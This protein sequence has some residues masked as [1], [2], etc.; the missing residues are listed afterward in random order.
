V[1]VFLVAPVALA[2][3][4]AAE[5]DRLR[6]ELRSLARQGRWDG[7][8]KAWGELVAT[9]VPP[10]AESCLQA[11]DAAQ[12]LGHLD[13]ELD[14][15]ACAGDTAEIRQRRESL[16]AGTATVALFG[17]KE[18]FE[19]EQMPFQPD[20]AR[21]IRAAADA[22]R[23]DGFWFGRLP[24]G[25]YALGDVSVRLDPDAALVAVASEGQAQGVGGPRFGAC[26]GRWLDLP[27]SARDVGAAVRATPSRGAWTLGGAMELGGAGV[28][29]AGLAGVAL[30]LALPAPSPRHLPFADPPPPDRGPLLTGV[31]AGVAGVGAGL[32]GVGLALRGGAAHRAEAAYPLGR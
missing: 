21:A 14:R 2:A 9:G 19:P 24:V 15:L 17:R 22:V 10:S 25:R 28:A 20:A 23:E 1:V 29:V 27:L 31:G 7:V 6:E 32:V 8:E 11:A 16:R 12:Q 30:G 13:A 18:A 4:P 3:D 26:G 5:A